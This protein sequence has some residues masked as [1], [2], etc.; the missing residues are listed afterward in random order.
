MTSVVTIYTLVFSNMHGTVKPF[1]MYEVK[2]KL[3]K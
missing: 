2:K 3:I 1:K